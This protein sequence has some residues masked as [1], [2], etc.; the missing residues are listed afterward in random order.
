L[1]LALLAAYKAICEGSLAPLQGQNQML[2]G[3]DMTEAEFERLNLSA[4]DSLL[5]FAEFTL[6]GGFIFAWDD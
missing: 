1:S 3:E 4:N 6:K 5:N 2:I